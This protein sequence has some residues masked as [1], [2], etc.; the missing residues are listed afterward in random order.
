MDDLEI[1]AEIQAAGTRFGVPFVVTQY[2]RNGGVKHQVPC[3]RVGPL[4][5]NESMLFTLEGDFVQGFV[6]LDDIRGLCIE[7][8]R[9]FKHP[10]IGAIVGT[11]LLGLPLLSVVSAFADLPWAPQ[12]DPLMCSEVFVAAL[13]AYMLWEVLR[14]RQVPFLVIQTKDEPRVF[15][16]HGH[17]APEVK[18]LVLALQAAV[19]SPPTQEL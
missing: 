19:S 1:L 12:S 6:Y 10:V 11:V 2:D 16:L 4:A 3:R 9:S 7:Q 15:Q 18:L 5:L 17:L 14:N 8:R 13:G